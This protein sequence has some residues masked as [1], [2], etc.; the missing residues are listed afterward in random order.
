MTLNPE[1]GCIGPQH[2]PVTTEE[3]RSHATIRA[4]A[5]I[6]GLLSR[7]HWSPNGHGPLMDI[8]FRS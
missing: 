6:D 3:D 1:S 7:T 2:I 8:R 4:L 5:G